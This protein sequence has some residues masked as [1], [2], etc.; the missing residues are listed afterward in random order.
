MGTV[1]LQMLDLICANWSTVLVIGFLLLQKSGKT[2]SK[3]TGKNGTTETNELFNIGNSKSY[4]KRP[5]NSPGQIRRSNE[6]EENLNIYRS[7]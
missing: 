7:K 2:R 6:K 5:H 3:N 4:Y 1:C